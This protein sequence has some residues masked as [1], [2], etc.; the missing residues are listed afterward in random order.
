MIKIAVA[1]PDGEKISDH[2][3]MAPFFSIFQVDD[4]TL[5]FDILREK[6]HK[7][8]HQHDADHQHEQ[9][10]HGLGKHVIQ[11]I[12]DCQVLICGGMG[13]PA[14]RKAQD[15]GLE[16]FLT[17]GSVDDAV[18]AYQKGE[19]QSDLRRIHTH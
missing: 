12:D 13:Q 10:G 14:F 19:L 18:H 5:L 8:S 2:F 16:V 17:G 1:T 6:P 9:Q 15:A 11:A 7:S 3:G 4:N